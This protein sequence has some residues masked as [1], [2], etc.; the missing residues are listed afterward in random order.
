M[1]N[2]KDYKNINDFLQDH[3]VS[4]GET[5]THTSMGKPFGAFNI[6]NSKLEVFYKLYETAIKNKEDVH[7]IEKHTETSPILVDLDFK[8]NIEYIERQYNINHIKKIVDLYMTEMEEIFKFT[9]K[10]N[11]LIAFVFE[12]SKPYHAKTIIKDGIHIIFPFAIT[13]PYAQYALRDNILKKIDSVFSDIKINNALSDVVDR[14]IIQKN[15][16]LMY[17]SKKPNCDPYK[18]TH[19]YDSY[20]Q[21]INPD[22]VD[23]NGI[24]NLAEFLSIRR[25]SLSSCLSLKDKNLTIKI[26]KKISKSKIKSNKNCYNI[27]YITQL[28]DILSVE[29]ATEFEK[30]LEVGICL[31]SIDHTTL[32]DVWIDF[33]KKS[34]SYNE[35]SCIHKWNE[36]T[37]SNKNRKE[38]TIASLIYWAKMDNFDSFMN[39]KRVDVQKRLEDTLRSAVPNNWDI[40]NVLYEMFQNQFVYSKRCWYE[41]KNHKWD[42]EE[43]GLCLRKKISNELVEE[44]LRLNSQY[45]DLAADAGDEGDDTKK[46][47]Y[48]NQTKKIIKI[49]NNIKSTSFKDNVMKECKEL[50]DNKQFSNKLDTNEYLIGFDNGVYDL[51]NMEFRDGRPDDHVTLSTNTSYI[52]YYDD[53]PEAEEIDD[54]MRKIVTDD[55]VR[56]YLLTL[57]SSFLQGVNAEEK[58]RV[59]TGSGSNGKS[60]LLEL[61]ISSFGDYCIK[62]PVT[63]LTGKRAQS[64]ACTPEIVQ[65][66]GK[67]FGYFDEPNENERINVGLMK[68]YTGGDK[69]KARG[70][71]KDPIEFKPQ[72]KLILLCNELPKVPPN[73]E[74][75]WRRMEVVEFK[76]KFIENPK[77]PYEFERDNYLS[78]KIKRWKEIFL[79]WLIDKYYRIYKNNGMSVPSEILK[80]TLEYKKTCDMYAEYLDEVLEK[81]ESTDV[82]SITELHEEFKLWHNEN[83]NGEKIVPKTK[84]KQFIGKKFKSN[85]FTNKSIRGYRFKGKSFSLSE[86]EISVI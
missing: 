34:S 56:L 9:N 7:V 25:H 69:I 60:K 3:K 33:S 23:Y 43:D 75:T 73:D 47:D 38:I 55:E 86:T 16:W 52:E 5:H 61:F 39:I 6:D 27:E 24:T 58:F 10:E 62:F 44:Y 79:S 49:I 68:E 83:Y 78:E 54:F 64:N 35:Q 26:Q 30:W 28:V 84:F 48:L 40:A 11:N 74:A 80:F 66:V 57:L 8:F 71:H 72:F 45:N 63:L 70:L 20:R 2:I 76:S 82:L 17:G 77:E 65:A 14:C 12:R 67:R 53:S 1:V 41:F 22:E 50:F 18:L 19:V 46:E 31:N 81:G 29:R 15:G 51:K 21:E 59:W 36:I 85:E 37:E 13:E 42:A 32:F 4:K